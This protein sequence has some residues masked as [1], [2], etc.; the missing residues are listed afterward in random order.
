M[1]YAPLKPLRLGPDGLKVSLILLFAVLDKSFSE[2]IASGLDTDPTFTCLQNSHAKIWTDER[3]VVHLFHNTAEDRAKLASHNCFVFGIWNFEE[4]EIESEI[5]LPNICPAFL[6]QLNV[7]GKV[8]IDLMESIGN[9]SPASKVDTKGVIVL[10]KR[11]D[12]P[13]PLVLGKEDLDYF[14]LSYAV[15]RL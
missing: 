5:I 3:I 14:N 15:C 1:H 4:N 13:E 2:S 6:L 11:K 12:L 7:P 10:N 8:S 9:V